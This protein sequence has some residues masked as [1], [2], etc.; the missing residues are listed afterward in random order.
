[1]GLES[2]PLVSSLT[3]ALRVTVTFVLS[4]KLVKSYVLVIAKLCASPTF[5]L[6]CENSCGVPGP[7]SR[8]QGQTDKGD[9]PWRSYSVTI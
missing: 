7:R 8:G 9:V 1:M 5:M 2:P 6:D 3:V 4:F